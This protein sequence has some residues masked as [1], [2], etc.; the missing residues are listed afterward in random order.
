MFYV[1]RGMII[2]NFSLIATFSMLFCKETATL[3]VEKKHILQW[4]LY[5]TS[6]VD[7][8][9]LLSL[10]YCLIE[11]MTTQAEAQTKMNRLFFVTS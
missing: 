5:F 9:L 1:G 3:T 4:Y 7:F 2:I 6:F 8:V 11:L 10:T